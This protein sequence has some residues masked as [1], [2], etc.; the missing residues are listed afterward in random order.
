MQDLDGALKSSKHVRFG[1]GSEKKAKGPPDRFVHEPSM[2]SHLD[3]KGI[4]DPNEAASAI[5]E[6]G[7]DEPITRK[8]KKLTVADQATALERKR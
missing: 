6:A 8:G 4:D 5:E 1:G 2:K 3:E 7:E